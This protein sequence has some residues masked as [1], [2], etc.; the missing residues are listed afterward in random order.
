MSVGSRLAAVLRARR[1][2]EDMARGDVARA[3]AAVAQ[4]SAGVARREEQL[5]GWSG[6][7]GGDPTAY[8]ASVAAGRAMAQALGAAE[9]ARREA[10]D[11]ATGRQDV[12][13]EAATRRRTVEKLTERAADQARKDE[14]AAAQRVV[15]DLWGGRTGGGQE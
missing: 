8:L 4:A 1:A 13:R 9:Q 7:E 3:N 10:E 14:L 6:P 12:L 5:D 15:D 2:Q 11:A